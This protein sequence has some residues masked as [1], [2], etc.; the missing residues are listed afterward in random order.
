MEA[1]SSLNVVMGFLCDLL[2]KQP[3]Q[4]VTMRE[5]YHCSKISLWFTGVPMNE[6]LNLFQATILLSMTNEKLNLVNPRHYLYT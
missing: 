6:K 4:N 2:D 5:V 1:Y 3:V